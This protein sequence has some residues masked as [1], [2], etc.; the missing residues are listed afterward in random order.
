G[1]GS[2]SGSRKIPHDL[3]QKIKDA[4]N[5][6]EVIGEHVVLRKSGSNYTGLCPFHSERSPSFSVSEQKQL[7]HCYGCKKGGDLLSFTMEIHGLSFPEAIEEL[8][9][10]ARIA[11]PKDFSQGSDTDDPEVAKK[12]AEAR[13]K[14]ATA[15]KLNRFAAAF[16]HQLLGQQPTI[17]HYLEKRGVS[18]DLG[19]NFYVGAAPASWDALATHLVEKKAP[20]PLAV[21]LGL[22]KPSTKGGRPG[23]PGYFDLFRNR[24]MFPILDLRG[25]V[26]G[27]G[28]RL[29]PAP[30]GALDVGGMDSP[31]YLNSN[32]SLVF[33]K[34][35]I[36]YGLFQAQKH[37]REKDE[38]ILVEGYFDVLA[39]HAA[40]FQNVVATCGTALT[41][42]HL[43]LFK[44]FC[45]RITVLFDGDRAG[46]TAT[47]R[48]MEIGLQHGLILHGAALPAG[49]DPDE[50]LFDQSTGQPTSTG[51]EQMK[52][53][54]AAAKPL[55]DARLEAAARHAQTGAEARTQALKQVGAWLGLYQ[56]PIGREVRIDA[57]QKQ[58]GVNR[59][60]M[61][62]VVIQG[63]G[64]VQGGAQQG[65]HPP[66]GT[67]RPGQGS[68]A[69]VSTPA[70]GPGPGAPNAGGPSAPLR[71]PGP[72]ALNRPPPRQRLS[73]RE[74][75]L[76]TA[77]AKS[78]KYTAFI[79]D[80][81]QVTGNLPRGFSLPDLFENLAARQFVELL[82]PSPAVENPSA[83]YGGAPV[84]PQSI[85]SQVQDSQIH[86][87]LTE[88][89]ISEDTPDNGTGLEENEVKRACSNAI[90]DLWARFS[91]QLRAALT[92]AELKKDERLEAE[93][94]KEYLDVRR[95][96]KEFSRFYDEA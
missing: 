74:K 61:D 76:L 4:V 50:V 53:I 90:A 85:L 21:E 56:D 44:K 5:I 95:K 28:G 59:S 73:P 12:R 20:L 19:R 91:H 15:S 93:L 22:I 52:T 41:P 38:V 31:K 70:R 92:D 64:Q 96:I 10:R 6:I 36:A 51:Q 86:A 69:R 84:S 17:S 58:F 63:K 18:G 29:L 43:N 68:P 34:S 33:H 75:L 77:L 40:G 57:I 1:S 25:K 14:L 71:A 66:S 26:A 16:Y 2:G 80:L 78:G 54:L 46:I 48:A 62:Q 60:L 37:V 32:E 23:G 13:E 27:F 45:S 55:L 39:L 87:L 94:K 79:T 65:R 11:L 72:V 24:A 81:V 89:L 49:L 9:E 35:K 83:D 7:Y 67:P 88:A 82:F 42:D 3:L 8:A 30:E 47:D